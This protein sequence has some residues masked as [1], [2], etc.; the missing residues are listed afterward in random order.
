MTVAISAFLAGSAQAV[1]VAGWDFSDTSSD[2]VSLGSVD[3]NYSSFDPTGGAGAESAT[4]GQATLTNLIARGGD[5]GAGARTGVTGG[6]AQ[7]ANQRGFNSFTTLQ[8]EG[9]AFTLP[10]AV[11]ATSGAGDAVFEGDLTTLGGGQGGYGW[12]ISFA[13]QVVGASSATVGVEFAPDCV[14]YSSAGSVNLDDQAN[15]YTVAFTKVA[16]DNACARL[17]IPNTGDERVAVDNVSLDVIAVPEPAVGAQL[18]AGAAGL[19]ALF[20]RK[21]RA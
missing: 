15:E 6:T 10:M 18:L 1:E 16:S 5:V 8:L 11:T 19:V 9:Q 14:S 12:S 21:A 2:G 3:A 7:D 4:Y 13:G 17:T 20:R